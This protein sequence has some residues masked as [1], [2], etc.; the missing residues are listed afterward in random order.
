MLKM[1]VFKTSFAK[2]L[3]D[4][5]N[6]KTPKDNFYP[7]RKSKI[8]IKFN[9][10]KISKENAVVF[11]SYDEKFSSEDSVTTFMAKQELKQRYDNILSE[12]EKENKTL[13]KSFKDITSGFNYEKEMK[14]IKIFENKSFYEI[15]DDHLIEIEKSEQYY[16]FK[17]DD[18]FDKLGKVKN[19]VNNH[20][21]LIK[22]YFN[23]YQELLSQ[24]HIFKHTDGGDFG[25]NHA[26]ELEKALKNDR[27]FKANHS[28]MIA[29]EKI[30]SYD[31]LSK[32]FEEEKNRILD[33]KELKERFEKIEESINANR[34]LR[35]FKDAISK[36]ITLLK[37]LLDYD[38]FKKR[39]CLAI[40]TKL[41]KML[42]AWLNSIERKS[43]K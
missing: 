38:S 34:E 25:T 26:D 24:S 11:H 15:L 20:R 16:S 12:L 33:D 32:I 23:K 43:L 14:T 37:E 9:G 42:K 1:G 5:I 17:Y 41:F 6:N 8:E 13:L 10:E 36:D 19:F 4:L 21:D 7:D 3:T 39:C 35:A 27:F 28:L 31:K 22:Q 29:G 30:T 18:I 2:S 40:L